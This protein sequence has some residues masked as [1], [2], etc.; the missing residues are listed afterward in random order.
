MGKKKQQQLFL[1]DWKGFTEFDLSSVGVE[2]EPGVDGSTYLSIEALPDKTEQERILK[3]HTHDIFLSIRNF[4]SVFAVLQ[5]CEDIKLRADDIANSFF[6]Y[7][8]NARHENK[9]EEINP[10]EYISPVNLL[11]RMNN[12]RTSSPFGLENF[13]VLALMLINEAL[14][15]KGESSTI[16]AIEAIEVH[17][18]AKLRF[19]RY[20]IREQRLRKAISARN[21]KSRDIIFYA[22][23]LAIDLDEKE[24]GRLSVL[25]IAKQIEPLVWQ[26][27]KEVGKK[28]SK[29]R[30]LTTIQEWIAKV[31]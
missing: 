1:S 31:I 29:D 8:H 11:L 6:A 20:S 2:L 18:I 10:Q 5:T 7:P 19:H 12:I 26:K 17:G 27:T 3:H 23:E 22:Q 16:A 13:Y 15:L 30:F 14:R 25:Q 9:R 28:Y 4:S 21:K 24:K